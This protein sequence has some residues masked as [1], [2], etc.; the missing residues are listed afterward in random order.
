[1]KF[2]ISLRKVWKYGG[3]LPQG[4]DRARYLTEL[5]GWVSCSRTISDPSRPTSMSLVGRKFVLDG[6]HLSFW[7]LSSQFL[8]HWRRVLKWVLLRASESWGNPTWIGTAV[9]SSFVFHRQCLS[10][11]LFW[12]RVDLTWTPT[13]RQDG[14]IVVIHSQH[15]VNSLEWDRGV[16][17]SIQIFGDFPSHFTEITGRPTTLEFWPCVHDTKSCGPE[18]HLLTLPTKTRNL[19]SIGRHDGNFHFLEQVACEVIVNW[20]RPIIR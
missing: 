14:R 18:I 5:V 1:L 17:L 15:R 20:I 6:W 8:S 10:P 13:N 4:W 3:F 2:E 9:F 11:V 7:W 16:V 12:F 19:R